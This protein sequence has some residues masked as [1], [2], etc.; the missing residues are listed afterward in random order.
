MSG[1]TVRCSALLVVTLSIAATYLGVSSAKNNGDPK[2]IGE[3]TRQT[4]TVCVGRLVIELPVG[5][6]IT[7]AQATIGGVTIDTEDGFTSAQ[8]VAHLAERESAL[9][10]ELNEY[11]RPS[12]EKRASVVA[13]NFQTTVLYSARAKP[14]VRMINGQKGSS[15]EE[16]ITVEALGLKDNNF[17]RFF[18]EDMSSP[19]YEERV[20]DLVKKFESRAGSSVPAAPGFCTENGLVHDP[21]SPDENE[22]TTMF[23]TLK[24]HPDIV[25]RLDTAVVDKPEESLLARNARNEVAARFASRLTNLGK[26]ARSLNGLAG[27][28]VLVRIKEDSGTSNHMFRWFSPGRAADVFSPSITLELQTGKGR[29]GQTI[30]SS[31]ADEAV[32][33][34]WKEISTSLKLRHTSIHTATNDVVTPVTPLGEL[35]ATGEHCPRG[36]YWR[37]SESGTGMMAER[38]FFQQGDVMPPARLRS[39]PSLWRKLSGATPEHIIPTVWTL[40]AYAETPAVSFAAPGTPTR[41]QDA[42]HADRHKA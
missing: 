24:N 23:A 29:P 10:V 28:E 1:R 40:V 41:P 25:I 4:T 7:F 8:V 17:Y 38:N 11:G 27:E 18:G 5:A 6:E 33:K 19:K 36:G 30:N 12:L 42:A 32:L 22:T 21:I 13:K 37:C 26:G 15:G 2:M 20:A 31:L 35:I 16:G 14:I 3:M 9:A 34:L 39:A